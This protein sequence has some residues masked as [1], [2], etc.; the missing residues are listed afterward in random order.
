VTLVT[1]YLLEQADLALMWAIRRQKVGEEKCSI[2]WLESVNALMTTLGW[3]D[4]GCQET[5]VSVSSSDT[6][7]ISS[8]SAVFLSCPDFTHDLVYPHSRPVEHRN[9]LLFDQTWNWSSGKLC[10]L[11][12]NTQLWKTRHSHIICSGNSNTRLSTRTL[13][14]S[15]LNFDQSSAISHYPT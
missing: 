15:C 12:K 4:P 1:A 9:M 13:E 3:K 7:T 11:G 5:W 2:R 6:W 10:G 8:L 14:L